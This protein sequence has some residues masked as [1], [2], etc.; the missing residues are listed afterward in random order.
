MKPT[1]ISVS[2]AHSRTAFCCKALVCHLLSSVLFIGRVQGVSDTPHVYH[3]WSRH[4]STW[5]YIDKCFQCFLVHD[6]RCC[7]VC[8][9]AI[10]LFSTPLATS[11]TPTNRFVYTCCLCACGPVRVTVCSSCC[12]L[13]TFVCRLSWTMVHSRFV[14]GIVEEEQCLVQAIHA[15]Y[16]NYQCITVF[17]VANTIPVFFMVGT[18][19]ECIES[20]K[21]HNQQQGNGVVVLCCA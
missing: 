15:S 19:I 14:P 16:D 12:Q 13:C 1:S 8:S 5:H 20:H 3:Q 10:A 7:N 4:V 9:V 17:I 11:M 6:M 2:T 21:A 18:C